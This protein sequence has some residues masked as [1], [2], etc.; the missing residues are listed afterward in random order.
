MATSGQHSFVIPVYRQASHLSELILSL[1]SQRGLRSEIILATS[2]PSV[3]L[4]ALAEL[5]GVELKVNPN[6]QDIAADWNFA[7]ECAGRRFVTIA[8]QDDLYAPDYVIALGN[9]FRQHVG[10]IIAFCDYT[11]H[12]PFGPRPTNLN[13]LIKRAL[14][15]RAYRDQTYLGHSRDKCRLLSL[16]NPICCPTVM[17]DREALGPFSF[18]KGFRT[19]LDWMAWLELADTTGGFAYVPQRLLSKG[20]HPDSETSATIANRARQREDR[21]ILGL[22]WPRP[23][24]AAIASVYRLSYLGNRVPLQA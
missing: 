9:A 3:E 4:S 13:L 7:F 16:G 5:H 6:R 15:R 19:N 10:A 22:L 17:F 14:I 21:A 8:H 20:V 23:M 11:E 24:A 2:T 1:K 12:T 18:P